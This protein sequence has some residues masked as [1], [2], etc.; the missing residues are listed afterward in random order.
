MPCEEPEVGDEDRTLNLEFGRMWAII[1]A[2][3]K[4]RCCQPF[5]AALMPGNSW[6]FS[7]AS[8]GHFDSNSETADTSS[9]SPTLLIDD[10]FIC[11]STPQKKPVPLLVSNLPCRNG[12]KSREA[13]DG[14]SS[15]KPLAS[16]LAPPHCHLTSSFPQLLLKVI[17]AQPSLTAL[18]VKRTSRKWR[19]VPLCSIN[20]FEHI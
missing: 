6:D 17:E 14:E 2:F 16:L 5:Q 8:K 15:K 7:P 19:M 4:Y 11:Y 13:R 20:H 1:F 9:P 3:T 10:S 18:D 12:E